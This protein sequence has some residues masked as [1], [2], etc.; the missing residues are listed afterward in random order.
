GL[1]EAV[2]RKLAEQRRF[3][4]WW[5]TQKKATGARGCR[6]ETPQLAELGVDK[7]TVHRWRRLKDDRRY[8]AAVAAAQERCRRICEGARGNSA[9]GTLARGD[10]EWYTP[11]E[12]VEAARDV[13]GGIDLDPASNHLA[14][15]T[16]RATRY[17]TKQDDG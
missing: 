16:V 4:M 10:S 9:R 12:Y 3:V 1:L 7:L 8:A 2:A 5:D 14:Q 13:L 17:F 15:A 11:P 6:S